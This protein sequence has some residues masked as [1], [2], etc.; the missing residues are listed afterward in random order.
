MAVIGC[1]LYPRAAATYAASA[2]CGYCLW[3]SLPARDG[4]WMQL[5]LMRSTQDPAWI[6]TIV[7]IVAAFYY[8]GVHTA[9]LL[10]LQ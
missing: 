5:L 8:Y 4:C 3:Q 6:T 7:A 1:D 2:A 10:H 9:R